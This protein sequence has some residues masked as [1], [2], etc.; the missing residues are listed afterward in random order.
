MADHNIPNGPGWAG[1][2]ISFF[3]LGIG[4]FDLNRIAIFISLM[5]GSSTLIYNVIKIRS[6]VRSG[7]IHRKKS[8]NPIKK[9]SKTS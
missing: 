4:V 3:F 5:A 7:R 1:T 8:N 2:L 9:N 6:E